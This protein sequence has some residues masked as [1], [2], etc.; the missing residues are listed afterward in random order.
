MAANANWQGYQSTGTGIYAGRLGALKAFVSSEVPKSKVLVAKVPIHPPSDDFLQ[1]VSNSQPFEKV[2]NDVGGL[3]TG[4]VKREY[5]KYQLQQDMK[6]F[7]I[8]FLDFSERTYHNGTVCK[9]G[10]CCQYEI[11]ISDN[12]SQDDNRVC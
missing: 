2:R 9:N 5:D 12:G 3:K 11:D 4:S 1:S 10:L 7:A 8:E 6:S